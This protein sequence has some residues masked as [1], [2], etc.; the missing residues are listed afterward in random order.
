MATAI[1]NVAGESPAIPRLSESS[2]TEATPPWRGLEGHRA[3]YIVKRESLEHASQTHKQRADDQQPESDSCAP[4]RLVYASQS[5]R[6][7]ENRQTQDEKGGGH[8]PPVGPPGVV[9]HGVESRVVFG[10]EEVECDATIK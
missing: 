5:D 1:R 4:R 9:A 2:M 3:S 10:L 7:R 8:E 6:D